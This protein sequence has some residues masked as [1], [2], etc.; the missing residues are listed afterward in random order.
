MPV[1]VPFES[2]DVGAIRHIVVPVG[3]NGT[4]VP[5]YFDSGGANLLVDSAAQRLGLKASGTF[6]AGGAGSKE[7]SAHVAAV[8]TVDF[9]GAGLDNQNF[10]VTPLLYTLT[11]P[12][13]GLS[14]DGLIGYEYLANYRVVIRYA[15]RRIDLQP[16]G[17]PAP[18]GGV[19][20]PF[21]SDGSHAYVEASVDGETGYYLLDTGNGGGV[22]LNALFVEAH[23]LF[24]T[25]GLA[26][27][28]PG[29]LGGA[30]ATT[31]VAAKTFKLAGATFADMPIGIPHTTAGAFATRGVAGNL[32]A[33]ILSRFTLVFDYK[34]QTVTFIPN[35]DAT[36]K[37]DADRTG[38]SLNQAD[39]SAFEVI[40]VV[41]GS[42]AAG[43]GVE[44]GDRIVAVAGTPVS[45][46]LGLGDMR[47]YLIGNAPFTLTLAHGA[48]TKTV[49][50][51]PRDIL[52]APQ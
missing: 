13:K 49:T 3:L 35:A 1:S 23:H 29:G 47:P 42:P 50:L 16:F 44:K 45:S 10:I 25:G 33:G 30:I 6:A 2:D 39:A 28:S 52:P 40:A 21:K 15:E 4:K 12:R 32:G 5:V 46:G 51:A 26:Y 41:P 48:T 43:A 18:T 37:F 8:Q 24:P 36:K 11:H 34:A 38:L 9:A 22:D 31:L 17:V 7:Q 20:L 27:V 14:V 19:A